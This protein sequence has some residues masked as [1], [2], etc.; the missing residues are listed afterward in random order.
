[1]LL[2]Q[3]NEGQEIFLFIHSF[4]NI[5]KKKKF[6]QNIFQ[7]ILSFCANS[8]LKKLLMIAKVSS[9]FVLDKVNGLGK[10]YRPKKI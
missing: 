3:R 7:S 8:L 1:M 9:G 6:V 5:R 2:L 10:L 4:A